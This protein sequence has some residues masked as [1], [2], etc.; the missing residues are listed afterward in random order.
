MKLEMLSKLPASL[1]ASL[2][3]EDRDLFREGLLHDLASN[4]TLYQYLAG[5]EESALLSAQQF[6]G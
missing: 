5:E 4:A 6:K 3:P 2:S 1:N